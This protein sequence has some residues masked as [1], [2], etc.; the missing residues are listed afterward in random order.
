MEM[1]RIRQVW[2]TSEKAAIEAIDRSIRLVES[3][4]TNLCYD[5]LAFLRVPGGHSSLLE[6][7]CWWFTGRK[8]QGLCRSSISQPIVKRISDNRKL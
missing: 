7:S 2:E 5:K 8:T 4:W 6:I 3:V 1:A